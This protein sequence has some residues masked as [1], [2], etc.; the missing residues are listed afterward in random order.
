M[1]DKKETEEVVVEEKTK[2]KINKLRLFIYL[3]NIFGYI[4]ILFT[5]DDIKK[6]YFMFIGIFIVV[7]S[8]VLYLIYLYRIVSKKKKNIFD[9][10]YNDL[11]LFVFNIGITLYILILP[12]ATPCLFSNK[13]ICTGDTCKC[14][15]NNKNVI[16]EKDSL[17]LEQFKEGEK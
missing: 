10:V 13:C 14:R 15:N 4:I 2:K 11:L 12:I 9:V 8:F 5:K 16:C 3:L 7:L 17:R 1:K 6:Y